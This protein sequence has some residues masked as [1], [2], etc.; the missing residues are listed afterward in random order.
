MNM[1]ETI[2]S[3]EAKRAAEAAAA[4]N[5]L[6]KANEEGRSFDAEEKE[7]YLEHKANTKAAEDH[8]EILR[9]HEKLMVAN[10]TRVQDVVDENSASEVRGGNTVKAGDGVLRP[11]ANLP[12]GMPF[13]RYTMALAMA[14]GN[15]MQAQ[16]IAKQWDTSTPEVG[17]VL[18]F[19]MRRG[20]T[21]VMGMIDA[22]NKAAVAAGTTTA[23]TWAAPLVQY[24]NMAQAFIDYL[25]PATI[26]GRLQGMQ[27]VP[28]YTRIPRQTAGSTGY[29]VGEGQPKPLS[30]LAFDS[31]T[32]EPF[33]AAT[34]I[35]I[36]TELARFSSPDAENLVRADMRRGI[37]QF[38]DQRFIDP[39][40]TGNAVSPASITNGAS[41]TTVSATTIAATDAAIETA[42]GVFLTADMD[43]GSLVWIMSPIVAL[44]LSLK[45]N[46]N[47]EF[48][49]PGLTAQGGTWMGIPVITSNTAVLAGSPSE[50][51]IALVDTS[52][53]LF[54]DDG[55]DIDVS[56]EASV[57]M[58]NAPSTGAASLVSLWQN[59]MLGFRAE[60]FINWK[61]RRSTHPAYV[62]RYNLSPA[63]V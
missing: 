5:L 4:D 42:L 31:V 21:R 7:K 34:I 6:N 13:V 15:V 55:L 52:N 44:S 8:L 18:D 38:L 2:A 32:M 53:I 27:R 57:Q 19:A 61:S 24:N 20:T 35:V 39:Q 41:S 3:F 49:Y 63:A 25:R 47:D 59:N 33:K 14:K 45:R 9:G 62:L 22:I 37:A 43:V 29:F 16:E 10:A 51:I 28:F 50:A 26:L 12:E 1:K 11:N 23:T 60:Q 30:S 40:F 56:G 36:T 17:N 54:A 48:A 46:T 58:D